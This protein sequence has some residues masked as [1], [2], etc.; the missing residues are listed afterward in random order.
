MV[1]ERRKEGASESFLNALI[2]D[3]KVHDDNYFSEAEK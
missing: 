2:C 1:R 3:T